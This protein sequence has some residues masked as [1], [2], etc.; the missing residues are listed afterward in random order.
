MA[1]GAENDG[2]GGLE[3]ESAIILRFDWEIKEVVE[4]PKRQSRRG[5]EKCSLLRL[6]KVETR[7]LKKSLPFLKQWKVVY[8][9]T[10]TLLDAQK[11]MN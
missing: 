4:K 10:E 3:F 8:S 9:S 6:A 2:G 1:S 7:Y 11:M 5:V